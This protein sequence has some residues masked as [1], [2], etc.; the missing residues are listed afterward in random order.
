MDVSEIMNLGKSSQTDLH[1]NNCYPK[2]LRE[3][4]FQQ[5]FRV[6]ES[7]KDELINCYAS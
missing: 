7:L 5:Q 6:T 3:A 2:A 1:Q 4:I